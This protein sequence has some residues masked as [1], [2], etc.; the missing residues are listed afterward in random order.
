[1]VRFFAA[2][3]LLHVAVAAT[4]AALPLETWKDTRLYSR[5]VFQVKGA[6]L[7]EALAPQL[8]RY[9]LASDSYVTA[10]VL[11]YH[12]RRDVPV[13]GTGS[14][15]ARHDDILTDWRSYA[16][17]DLLILRRE[18]PPEEDY[19]RFFRDFDIVP[20]ELAGAT[21]YAVRGRGFQF[22][23]YRADILTQVRD[24]YYR[25]P[26]ILPVGRCYFFERYF[27]G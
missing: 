9:A 13:F 7:I 22:E 16:G 3:A 8:D 14:S 6:E 21:F 17:K 18:R 10:A 11:A 4:V 19:R 12:S 1:V 26:R 20:V 25:I 15:H 23:A 24:R 27:P 2:F 5:L